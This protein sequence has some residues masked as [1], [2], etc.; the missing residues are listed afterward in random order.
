MI[1]LHCIRTETRSWCRC[2]LGK[3]IGF[4]SRSCCFFIYLFLKQISEN[5]YKSFELTFTES[6]FYQCF[7]FGSGQWIRIRNLDPRG[8]KWPPKI[9]KS[10]K[11]FMFWSAGCSLSRA[12]CSTR[13]DIRYGDLRISKYRFLSKKIW[14]QSF[15]CTFFSIFGR[16]NPGSGL[17]FSQKCWIRIR[18]QLIRIR[19]TG[20]PINSASKHLTFT[21]SMYKIHNSCI[22][23]V[24][25]HLP[26]CLERTVTSY[27]LAL[28]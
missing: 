22:Q 16:Q 24:R 8:Q 23:K 2:C 9:E 19:N 6:M 18:N 21:E 15:S 14:K 11:I 10:S 3:G 20:F 5:G 27:F 17:V 26:F 4:Q 7:E 25:K 28:Q 12:S 1:N 13:L